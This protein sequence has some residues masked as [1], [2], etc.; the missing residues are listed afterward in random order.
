MKLVAVLA[1]CCCLDVGLLAQEKPAPILWQDPGDV[2]QLDFLKGPGTPPQAPFRFEKEDAS[3]SSAKLLVRDAGNRQWSVKFG[4]E[5]KPEVFGSRLAWAM[6]YIVEPSYLVASG[7]VE[8]VT[9]GL[10]RARSFVQP[11]GSFTNGRFQIRSDDL[12][13][14]PKTSW[15]WQ[16]SPFTGTPQL[17]GLKI[18]MMLVSNWD[19]KD[20]R[21]AEEGTNLLM[22]E[23]TTES[24]QKQYAYVM[25]DWGQILGR[26]GSFFRR[27]NWN[28]AQFTA[29]NADFI[30][31]VSK[32]EIRWG[33][34]GRHNKSFTSGIK[35]SDAAWLLTYLGRVTDKQWH[36][37]L[38]SAGATDAEADCFAS[39]LEKRVESLR[40]AAA[41]Q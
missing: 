26:W 9:T 41:K 6:G 12:K 8:G 21:D 34:T 14:I 3:G 33:Y 36:D 25:N 40:Q 15:S 30:K 32:K 27:T 4:E 28:C 24:G 19:N 22:F 38:K 18:L 35:P 13:F 29:D 20:G 31:G 23:R 39:A 37:G 11:D 7:K 16:Y 2:A 10:T 17:N 1:F 5:A